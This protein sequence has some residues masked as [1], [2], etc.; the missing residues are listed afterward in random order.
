MAM[1]ILHMQV[2][3]SIHSMFKCKRQTD[4]IT[5]KMLENKTFVEECMDKN[6]AFLKL[7]PKSVQYWMDHKKDLFMMIC[8]LGKPAVYNCEHKRN[9]LAN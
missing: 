1:K 8:R 9:L 3:E 2:V 6:L 5:H 4:N 7:I